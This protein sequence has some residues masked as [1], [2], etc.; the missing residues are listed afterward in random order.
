MRSMSLSFCSRQQHDR[1]PGKVPID[2][3][4][5]ERMVSGRRHKKVALKP[6]LRRRRGPHRDRAWVVSC[7]HWPHLLQRGES[8]DAPTGFCASTSPHPPA[9]PA[10]ARTSGGP[11]VAHSAISARRVSCTS[12]CSG[13]GGTATFLVRSQPPLARGCP[14]SGDGHL[15]CPPYCRVR[16]PPWHP[17]VE[18]G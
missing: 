18:S 6:R 14:R 17:M 2:N 4:T 3:T 13:Q 10:S 11:H 1:E 12:R 5:Q 7:A 8:T 9:T 15:L 16:L